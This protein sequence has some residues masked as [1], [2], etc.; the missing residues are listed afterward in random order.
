[1]NSTSVDRAKLGTASAIGAQ[2]IFRRH[3]G[4]LREFLHNYAHDTGHRRML[5]SKCSKDSRARK[6]AD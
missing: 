2:G 4:S 5:P 3:G 1:M 6:N